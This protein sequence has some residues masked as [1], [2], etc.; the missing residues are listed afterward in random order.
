MKREIAL[1]MALCLISASFAISAEEAVNF[2]TNENFFVDKAKEKAVIDPSTRI[3][4]D[5]KSY[6]VVTVLSGESPSCM[7]PVTDKQ[8]IAIPKDKILTQN[9]IETAYLLRLV[10]STRENYAK[11]GLW[12]LTITSSALFGAVAIALNNEI[13]EL[14]LVEKELSDYTEL[15]EQAVELQNK[16][17]EMR[18]Y[19]SDVAS[20]INTAIEF[21]TQ[22]FS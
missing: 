14:K 1:F 20:K 17:E 18:S 6:W 2:I 21:E 3:Y 12:P 4:A 13:Y 19:A 11:Q 8:P 15:A 16:V 5:S 22:F 10:N 7:I 9:L